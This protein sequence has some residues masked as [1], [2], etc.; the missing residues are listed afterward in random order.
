[1]GAAFRNQPA[2]LAGNAD[3]IAPEA[4]SLAGGARGPCR[5]GVAAVMSRQSVVRAD[6]SAD[7]A[8][9][10]CQLSSATS[11]QSVPV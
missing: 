10:R 2:F 3:R 4:E 7:A 8:C 11:D 9:R 5:S 1:M 6:N